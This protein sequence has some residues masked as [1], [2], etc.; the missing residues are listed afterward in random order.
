MRFHRRQAAT[1]RRP[2]S[3]TSQRRLST[4]FV[5]VTV[6]VVGRYFLELTFD[7][8]EVRI[9]DFEPLM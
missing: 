3:G 9:L 7:S 4:P 6:R 1:E 8:G 2:V 5:L